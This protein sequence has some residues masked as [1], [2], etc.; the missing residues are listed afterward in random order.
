[1]TAEG[2]SKRKK[3]KETSIY[4]QAECSCGFCGEKHKSTIAQPNERF[5]GREQTTHKATDNASGNALEHVFEMMGD[6]FTDYQVKY[7]TLSSGRSLLFK[8]RAGKD[9]TIQVKTLNQ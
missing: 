2:L 3:D 7:T 5:V 8:D 4:R 6:A 9:H 1:M